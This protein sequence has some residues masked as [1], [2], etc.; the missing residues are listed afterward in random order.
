VGAGPAHQRAA[1]R[2]HWGR[3][4]PGHL[5]EL[6][7]HDA[8][9]CPQLRDG[10]ARGRPRCDRA[11]ALIRADDHG[12]RRV[13]RS[14]S[15]LRRAVE[16]DAR[17]L[18]AP[19]LAIDLAVSGH[20]VRELPRARERPD[21]RGRVPALRLPPKSARAED[22]GSRLAKPVRSLSSCGVSSVTITVFGWASSGCCRSRCSTWC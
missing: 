1:W 7:G 10:P 9:D 12:L 13:R 4:V 15:D 11:G 2:G 3:A 20:L 6:D 22:S 5:R 8:L 17:D 16:D 18:V 19:S 14:V 21:Q